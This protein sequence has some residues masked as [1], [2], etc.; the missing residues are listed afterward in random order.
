MAGERA[1]VVPLPDPTVTDPSDPSVPSES[2]PNPSL[3]VRSL[4]SMRARTRTIQSKDW[5]L[6]IRWSRTTSPGGNGT[7][8]AEARGWHPDSNLVTDDRLSGT[9]GFH[10]LR[11]PLLVIAGRS[12]HRY[13]VLRRTG[14]V[15]PSPGMPCSVLRSQVSSLPE[16]RTLCRGVT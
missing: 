8:L 4:T 1:R 10:S 11:A 2:S 6:R 5:P 7:G 9:Q 14:L 15:C 13:R 3:Q 12:R 16:E